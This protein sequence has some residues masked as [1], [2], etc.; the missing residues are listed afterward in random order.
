MLTVIGA[1]LSSKGLFHFLE[2]HFSSKDLNVVVVD[3]S[4]EALD[5]VPDLGG[6]IS[7]LEA[8]VSDPRE[9]EKIIP[10]GGVTISL[11]PPSMHTTVAEVCLAKACHLITASYMTEELEG[12]KEAAFQKGLVF[13]AECGLDPGLDH[14]LAEQVVREANG[15]NLKIKEFYSYAGGLPAVPEEENPWGYLLFW[16]PYNVVHAGKAGATF[17]EGREK[18]TIAHKDIFSNNYSVPH[19]DGYSYEAYPNR[20]SLSYIDKY[21]LTDAETVLRGTIRYRGF[22]R[23]WRWLVGRGFTSDQTLNTPY[24]TPDELLGTLDP[25]Y[26]AQDDLDEYLDQ[27]FKGEE[28]RYKLSFLGLGGGNKSYQGNTPAEWLLNVLKDKWQPTKSQKDKVVMWVSAKA[29]DENNVEYEVSRSFWFTSET[30]LSAMSLLVGYPLGLAFQKIVETQE[31]EAGV[32]IP[33]N[34]SYSAAIEKSFELLG[35]EVR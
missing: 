8:D 30:D 19:L 21:G 11:L 7:T 15:K 17:L 12:L 31:K 26:A 13:L 1:G 18:K 9:L 27:T 23:A 16:N 25:T 22:M 24:A 6:I 3:A 32:L 5:A 2:H 29:V 14:V 20:D 35:V 34:N 10:I 28:M 33:L 4:K